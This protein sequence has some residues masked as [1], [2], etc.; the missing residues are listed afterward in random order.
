MMRT[1]MQAFRS[2]LAPTA[3]PCR[4]EPTIYSRAQPP[5]SVWI[6]PS[7]EEGASLRWRIIELECSLK[8]A[9]RQVIVAEFSAHIDRTQIKQLQALLERR[10]NTSTK[11]IE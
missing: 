3:P 9:R 8:E 2:G 11:E 4:V 5:A 6:R 10:Q 1:I 7:V